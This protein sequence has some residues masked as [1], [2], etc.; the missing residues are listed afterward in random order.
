MTQDYQQ[1]LEAISKK[2]N[3]K[4]LRDQIKALEAESGQSGFW[5]NH[6]AASQKM[7]QLTAWQKEIKEFEALEDLFLK[8]KLQELEKK[9][10]RLEVRA[11]LSGKYDRSDAIFSIHAGQGGVEAMDWAQ[12]LQRMYFKYIESKDWDY[13]V[14]DLVFGEEAGVKSVTI[15]IFGNYVYGYLRREAGTHRLVRQ[16]PF[17]AD[18]KRQTSFALVEV[19]PILKEPEV[20]IK[21]DEIE[22]EAFRSSGHGGQNVNKVSTA[23][24]LKHKPTGIT[25]AC[26][27]QRYQEQNRKIAMEILISKIWALAQE[28]KAKEE[29][30]LKEGR[31]K[32]T[33][34]TQIRS[35]VLHPYKMVK[36]LRTDWETADADSVLDGDLDPLIEAEIKTMV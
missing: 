22:F 34:G 18:R 5:Q 31:T 32:A 26:Q 29:K 20:N 35:Y 1:R 14:T 30:D 11:Y 10:S 28:K 4:K 7:K 21:E 2:L 12:M 33:W 24:R 23:V 3:L 9:L 27:S 8:D 13:E 17:N 15:R 6:E 16:S 25:V 19:I 36:D